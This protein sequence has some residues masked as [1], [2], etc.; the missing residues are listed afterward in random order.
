MR[1][2]RVFRFKGSLPLA[3]PSGRKAS[4]GSALVPSGW[5][6]SNS[7]VRVGEGEDRPAFRDRDAAV[8]LEPLDLQVTP[9]GTPCDELRQS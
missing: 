8:P 2:K 4:V 1:L 6:T 3:G 7:T 5:S 9:R